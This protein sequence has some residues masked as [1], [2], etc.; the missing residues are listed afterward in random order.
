MITSPLE[1]AGRNRSRREVNPSTAPQIE[2]HIEELVFYGFAAGDRD[3][4]AEAVSSELTRL[5]AEQGAPV[6]LQGGGAAEVQIPLLRGGSFNIQPAAKPGA[7]G[8]QSAE[9]VYQA[10]DRPGGERP[11]PPGEGT[12]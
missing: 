2:L 3:A 11:V 1:G 9:A 12:R 8:L 6:L 10:L 4:L 5:L 7:L